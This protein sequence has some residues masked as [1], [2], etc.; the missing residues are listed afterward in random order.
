MRARRSEAL[1]QIDLWL[2][3]AYAGDCATLA[4]GVET[5]AALTLPENLGAH[6]IA[7]HTRHTALAVLCANQAHV[8]ECSDVGHGARRVY[9][10]SS[11]AADAAARVQL[12]T[13]R[14]TSLDEA[15]AQRR[16]TVVPVVFPV[17]ARACAAP[18]ASALHLL[19]A[20]HR[21]RAA[22]SALACASRR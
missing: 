22:L 3:V 10:A 7:F 1:V 16:V 8:W 12:S 4:P 20:S 6:Q 2:D 14:V 19:T 5:D 17:R 21:A 13:A 9:A 18:V 11:A 15:V